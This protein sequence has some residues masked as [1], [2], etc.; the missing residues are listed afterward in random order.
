MKEWN[1]FI[2]NQFVNVYNMQGVKYFNNFSKRL[3]INVPKI[4]SLFFKWICF[5]FLLHRYFLTTCQ[6]CQT[7]CHRSYHTL[8]WY[9]WLLDNMSMW[10]CRTSP[11]QRC[12]R[13]GVWF[14]F[15]WAQW[16]S[17]WSRC[18]SWKWTKGWMSRQKSDTRCMSCRRRSH[19]SRGS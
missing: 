6:C 18:R 7:T 4:V 1:I 8:A 5:H 10:L 17:S 9:P 11:G 14:S 15:H 13:F 3:K 19:Q 12:P 2:Q 16:S